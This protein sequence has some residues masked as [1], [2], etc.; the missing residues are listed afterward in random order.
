MWEQLSKNDKIS[1]ITNYLLNEETL[2]DLK[3]YVIQIIAAEDMFD[4][5][6]DNDDMVAGKL[7]KNF[8]IDEK[9]TYVCNEI[10]NDWDKEEL[11]QF[12]LDHLTDEKIQEFKT[13]YEVLN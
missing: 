5:W 4:N 8:T 6:Y 2:N 1:F 11:H 3:D 10:E 13:L 12:I 9:T 7:W